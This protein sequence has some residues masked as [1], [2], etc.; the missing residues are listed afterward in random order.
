MRYLPRALLVA[1]VAVSPISDSGNGVG[2]RQAPIRGY[3]LAISGPLEGNLPTSVATSVPY[4]DLDDGP[5]IIPPVTPFLSRPARDL[6]KVGIRLVPEVPTRQRGERFGIE[7]QPIESIRPPDQLAK[8][9]TASGGTPT[10]D[11]SFEGMN[12]A[13]GGGIAPADPVG[14]VGP[15]HYVQMVNAAF[16]AYDKTGTRVLGPLLINSLWTSFGGPCENDN[17][18]DPVVLYDQFA[19][20]WLLSQYNP[21]TTNTVCFAVSQTSDP[22]GAYYLYSYTLSNFPDYPKWGVWPDAYYLGTNTALLTY[23]ATAFDRVNM[24][25]GLAAGGVSFGSMTNFVMPADADGATFPPER[26]PGLFYTFKDTTYHGSESSGIGDRL[27]IWEF[28]VDFAVPGN[29]SFQ[30]RQAIPITNFNY[31]VCGFFVLSCLD[32][33]GTSQ[34]LDSRSDWPMHR[35]Q[36]RNFGSYE[37]LLGNFTVD[38]TGSHQAG[39]RWFEL[40]RSPPGSGSWALHQEGTHAPDTVNRWMGS[41]AMDGMGNIALGYSAGSNDLAP[42]LRYASRVDSDPAG[43]LQS[44]T[45]LIEGTG[46]QTASNRWGDYSSMN[47]DP[48][49]DLTFWFTGEYYSTTGGLNWSTRIGT[50]RI[51]PRLYVD[52]RIVL[53]GAFAGPGSMDTTLALAGH[54]PNHHPF[55]ASP[56]SYSGQD[57]FVDVDSSVVDWV[58]LSLVSGDPSSP[59]MTLE[60]QRAGFLLSDGRIVEAT[61]M[62]PVRFD[63]PP[64]GSYHLVVSARNHLPVMS[65]DTLTIVDTLASWDFRHLAASAFPGDGTAMK[66]LHSSPLI[67]IFGLVACDINVD[68]QITVSDFNSW[69]VDTKAVMTG[70]LPTDC[71]MDGQVTASDFNFWLPNTKSVYTSKV[72]AF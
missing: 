47:V 19:D 14:D 42:S 32:Q 3:E 48:V 67:E 63:V 70:Y 33:P 9:Q 37:T 34:L 10:P 66:L 23:A 8:A 55:T 44:E 26:A 21:V 1:G 53:E 27:E 40:R 4:P 61:G 59:P 29:S 43:Q 11:I 16:S 39:I 24:L 2:A 20:R 65:A 69:L 71:N 5:V 36:Y 25:S 50:F 49:D 18:G 12:M 45:S 41:I 51:E 57:I 46:V 58:L 7:P 52:S 64:D 54:V 72:P 56:W 31:T 38:V 62:G 28:D 15:N 13:D 17:Y 22:T 60:D 68:G 35:L 30:R 6:P